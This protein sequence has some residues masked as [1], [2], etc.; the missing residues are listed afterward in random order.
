[1]KFINIGPVYIRGGQEG[2]G[3]GWVVEKLK[4]RRNKTQIV[5]FRVAMTCI[6]IHKVP[7]FHYKA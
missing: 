1:M 4:Q 3:V 7:I 2:H 6:C 5:E